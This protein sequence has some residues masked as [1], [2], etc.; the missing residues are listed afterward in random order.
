M[1]H[2]WFVLLIAVCLT[3][4]LHPAAVNGAEDLEILGIEK[5][6]DSIVKV[7]LSGSIP[8]GSVVIVGAYA[9]DGRMLQNAVGEVSGNTVQVGIDTKGAEQL[10]AFLVDAKCQPLCNAEELTLPRLDGTV[11]LSLDFPQLQTSY[12][13]NQAETEDD[14]M[15]YYWGVAFTDGKNTFELATMHFKYP[16]SSPSE[17]TP[18]EMQT[19]L[20]LQKESGHGAKVIGDAVLQISGTTMT[21]QATIPEEYEFDLENMTITQKRVIILKQTYELM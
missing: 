11:T 3:I 2:W 6:N 21:W 10:R 16:D 17:K 9:N 13:V 14:H 12:T 8:D 18:Y 5:V 20:W 1:K 15:E 19:D 4:V 7:S